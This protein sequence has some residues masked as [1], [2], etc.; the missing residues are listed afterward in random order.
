VILG[1]AR[2]DGRLG[3]RKHL[4]CVHRVESSSF[5]TQQI[6]ATDWESVLPKA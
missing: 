1:Y 3:M 6:A 4:L 2:A 5:V